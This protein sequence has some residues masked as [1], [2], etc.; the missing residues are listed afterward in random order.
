MRLRPGGRR[1]RGVYPLSKG[2][3]SMSSIQTIAAS[4][5][6]LTT[7][8]EENNRAR[9]RRAPHCESLDGRQLLNGAWGGAG[10]HGAWSGMAGG[11]GFG[12]GSGRPDPAQIQQWNGVG[13][14][15]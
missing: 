14:I 8:P 6:G 2:V 7:L 10:T 5:L 9:S 12:I 15:D 4:L 1:R 13:G 3:S 11:R